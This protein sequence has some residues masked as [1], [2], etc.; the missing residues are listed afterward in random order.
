MVVHIFLEYM[1]AHKGELKRSITSL[2]DRPVESVAI[3]PITEYEGATFTSLF[4][5]QE[6][7]FST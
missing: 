5:M 2:Q 6:H 3:D 1:E 4:M 7:F